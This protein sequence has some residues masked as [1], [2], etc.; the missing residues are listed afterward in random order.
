MESPNLYTLKLKLRR[1]QLAY[2]LLEDDAIQIGGVKG[3]KSLN[4]YYI[5]LPLLIGL[6]ITGAGYS[7]DFILLEAS[8]AVFLIYAAYG[9]RVIQ[10]KKENNKYTKVIRNG[11]FEITQNQ[12]ITKLTLQSLKELEIVIDLV[13]K[14]TFEGRLIARDNTNFEHYILS[15]FSTEKSLLREDLEYVKNYILMRLSSSE[16]KKATSIDL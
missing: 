9:V 4:F 14:E 1:Y 10:L 15:F 13:G 6:T 11:E 12:Q 3:M 5:Y 16:E 8:G 2:H 7:I